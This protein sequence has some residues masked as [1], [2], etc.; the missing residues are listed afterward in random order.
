MEKAKVHVKKGD[1]VVV[2]SGRQDQVD[3]KTKE[4]LKEGI[5]G[6]TGKVLAV[7]LSKGTVIVEGVNRIKRAQR[8]TQQNPRGGFTEKE[9][10]LN[11]SKVRPICPSCGKPTRIRNQVEQGIKV[12]VCAK[13]GGK[14]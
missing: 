5:R 11:A 4:V 9:A 7:N 2:V 6:K 14:L 13:C 12:R 3:P 8:P 1:T 10:P